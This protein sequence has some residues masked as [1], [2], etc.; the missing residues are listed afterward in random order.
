[1]MF[2][3]LRLA[4]IW[5]SNVTDNGPTPAL[6]NLFIGVNRDPGM[7]AVYTKYINT[8]ISAGVVSLQFPM[9][10]FASCGPFG[11]YGSWGAIECKFSHL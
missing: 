1:M 7:T 10:H 2:S 5:S 8:L 9:I 11:K 4:L 6:T 3:T